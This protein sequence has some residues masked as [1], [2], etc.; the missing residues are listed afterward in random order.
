MA[1]RWKRGMRNAMSR[2]RWWLA[3]RR[4]KRG[5]SREVVR[6]IPILLVAVSVAA[7]QASA[8]AVSEAPRPATG[9]VHGA[10]SDGT[11]AGGDADQSE[12]PPIAR[13][14]SSAPERQAKPL[15]P[16]QRGL[17][18]FIILKSIERPFMMSAPR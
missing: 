4:L 2:L 9:E 12:A 7:A 1:L 15:D 11:R 6:L 14:G 5:A 8:E 3:R 10:A 13:S 16:A 17:L 18:P